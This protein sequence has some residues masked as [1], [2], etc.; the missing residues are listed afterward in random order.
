MWPARVLVLASAVLA[1][2]PNQKPSTAPDPFVK[3]RAEWARDLHVKQLD[4]M[5][6]LYAPDAAL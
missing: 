5:V 4:Q 3:I 1:A 6:M 2:A